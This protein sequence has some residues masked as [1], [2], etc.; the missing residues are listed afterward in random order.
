MASPDGRP[1]SPRRLGVAALLAGLVVVV[2]QFPWGGG[3]DTDPPTCFGAFFLWTVPCG[4][5]PTL[6]AGAFTAVLVWVVLAVVVNPKPAV[7]AVSVAFAATACGGIE[8]GQTGL[9]CQRQPPD[10]V[11][12]S[13]GRDPTANG[14]PLANLDLE[15][16]TA[17]EVGEVATDAGFGVTWRFEYR[18]GQQPESGGSGYAE[19]WCVPPPGGRVTD[20]AYDSLGRIVVFVDSGEHRSSVRAQPRLGWGCDEE[21]SSR[22]PVA[23]RSAELPS[24]HRPEG[25]AA[26]G[27]IGLDRH[28]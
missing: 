13:Q 15:A 14:E 4:G 12:R 9:E 8:F 27:S 26:G 19:C 6:L 3:I 22:A 5:W 20:A 1:P 7:L 21:V 2:L 16:M 28:A 24:A 10:G 17:E 25:C 18:V 23:A 11:D